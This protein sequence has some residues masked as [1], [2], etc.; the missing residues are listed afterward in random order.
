MIY[1]LLLCLWVCVEIKQE[2]EG[3]GSSIFRKSLD[4]GGGSMTQN[5]KQQ[6]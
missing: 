1:K 6:Q 2:V 5:R 4:F 3:K